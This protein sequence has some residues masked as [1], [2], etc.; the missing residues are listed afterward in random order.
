LPTFEA[1]RDSL[2]R[3]IPKGP[4][5][6]Q[7]MLQLA[8]LDPSPDKTPRNLIDAQFWKKANS[9]SPQGEER[10]K[11]LAAGLVDLACW[12]G[13]P[14]YIARGMLHNGRLLA[15]GSQLEWVADR[16]RTG[17]SDPTRCPGVKGLSDED[18][19]WLDRFVASVPKAAY[20]K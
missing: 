9:A 2:F 13:S 19:T 4:F 6:Y 17:K 12:G 3:D 14:P 1:W 8:A 16:L 11:I 10:E 18:W 5:H 20:K 15:T 7:T